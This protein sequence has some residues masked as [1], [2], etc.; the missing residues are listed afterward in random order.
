MMMVLRFF[1]LILVSGLV[2]RLSAADEFLQGVTARAS[3]AQVEGLTGPANL[4][5]DRGFKEIA[6]GSGVWTLTTNSYADGGCMWNAG[7]G[8]IGPDENPLVEFD[9]GQRAVLTKFRVWNHN[10]SPHRGFARVLIQYSE[11]D[12]PTPESWRSLTR[13]WK[14]EPAPKSDDYSGEEHVFDPPI[15]VRHVRFFC[16]ATHRTG[17]QPD[18][19]A[20]GKVR[21]VMDRSGKTPPTVTPKTFGSYPADCGWLNVKDAPCSA[22]GDGVTD[23]T[24]ALQKAI[25]ECQGTGRVLFIPDGTY[26]ISRTLKY[27]PGLGHG[28]NNLRGE[29]RERTVLRLKDGVFTNPAQP[30]PVLTL[31]FHGDEAT[32]RGS[33]DWFNNNVTNL[34]IDTGR[35]NPGAIGLQFYSNNTGSLRDTTIRSGDGRGVTG[36]DLGYFDMNGPLLVKQV[37]IDGF[38]IGIRTGGTVNSQTLEHITL[39]GQNQTGLLNEGQCLSIRKLTSRNAVTALESRFGVVALIEADLRGDGAAS[40]RPAV[41]SREALFARDIR[42]TGYG[43]AIQHE[44]E[45]GAASVTGPDVD[46]FV[47]AAP[48]S[49]FE[50]SGRSL[51][52]PVEETPEPPLDPVAAWASARNHR[53]VTE[54]DDTGALQRAL[55]SSAST[56]Y[57]PKGGSYH[58]TGSIVI[59]PHIRRFTGLSGTLHAH[60]LKDGELPVLRIEGEST[61]PLVIEDCTLRLPVENHSQRPVIIRNCEVSGRLAGRGP[62][63]FENVVGE[64]DVAAGQQLWARHFNTEKQGVHFRNE[65]GQV[66]FLGLKTERG[67]PLIETRAGGRIEVIGGLSYT[68]TKGDLGPMFVLEDSAGSFTI[69]EVCYTRSPY[70]VLVRETRNGETK[71]LKRGE[72]PL[73]PSFLQGSRLPLFVSG[74]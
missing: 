38:D 27:K 9:L 59:G 8:A 1:A 18:V 63:F 28:R 17:G 54:R 20:L 56:V 71:E 64:W 30:Q 61:A 6:P 21:F 39:T 22:A 4:V 49:V 74:R 32:R 70:Q 69:G 43:L 45:P 19:A 44:S 25:D 73:R 48:L 67:G 66:W 2:S 14:F 37:A 50:S 41:I 26:L 55:S 24:D 35:G 46:E 52:L 40:S 15:A 13:I 3:G 5:N 10:G 36:L 58:V 72:V 7:Y 33:A 65:G 62:V 47:S 34:T 29:N 16:L 51:R 60:Q 42:T 23:D 11:R 68:T 53:Q 31:G 57:L 12:R